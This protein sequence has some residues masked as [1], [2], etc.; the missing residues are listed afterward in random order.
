MKR[1]VRIIIPIFLS[2]AIIFSLGWY[3]LVYDQEFTRDVLVSS[4][5]Y[6]E[7]Q[8][9]HSF[10]GWLYDRAYAQAADNDEVAI[11]LAHQ[12]VKAGNYTLA[13]QT[14]S[15]A[16]RDGGGAELYIALS[17]IYVRQNKLRDAVEML[18]GIGDEKIRAQLEALRP[19]PPV[20]SPAPGLYSQYISI[21]LT[22]ESGQV[23][24]KNAT[25]YPSV[26]TDV[27]E[28]PIPLQ[29][30]EN[31]IYAVAV[32]E[33][34][35][36]SRLSNLGYTVGGVN[37][38]INFADQTM[39]SAI[40]QL[41]NVDE[42]VRI[43][44]SDLS[45]IRSFSVPAG[46]TSLKDLQYMTSLETLQIEQ[47]VSGEL[48]YLASL[49]NLTRLTIIDT[50]VKTE[51]LPVIGALPKLEILELRNCGLT[52]TSGL[53]KAVNLKTLD[54]SDNSIRNIQ[55]LSTMEQLHTLY[56]QHNAL[57]DLSSLSALVKL[58]NLNV[59]YNS[60]TTLAPISNLTGLHTLEAAYNK[61]A[62]VGSLAKM[63]A[64]KHL[65]L[66][67]NA[68]T[69]VAP[70][71][72]CTELNTLDVSDN[73]LTAISSLSALNKLTALDFSNNRVSALPQFAKDCALVTIDGTNNQISTLE[74]L[75]GLKN[76][77]N[78]F[79]DR[80][81]NISS[82]SALA[83]CPTLIQVNVSGTK[84][85]SLTTVSVLTDQSIIVNFDPS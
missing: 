13:E 45:E 44:S 52:T 76:L 56:L 59:S 61:L 21:T 6:F 18:D 62:D 16:I 85:H 68:I 15:R 54:L 72:A 65:I 42:S 73:S 24:A 41:L 27:Y 46:V 57:A 8:G 31:N 48:A 38:V 34:G 2:L 78:V 11:E 79:M 7:R 69:D 23:Y 70:L 64:L 10:A 17:D 84:I 50:A 32:A 83:K 63:T 40:R 80:N 26:D 82:V 67:H 60:L 51:E 12:H 37:E 77:N 3:L 20:A 9:N 81:A 49:N 14:L 25:Q 55:A 33:N 19:A 4:A 43:M 22:A 5:R 36:V 53:A 29:F 58:E 28:S 66:E 75:G 30:G 47:S 39:E 35:L 1:A 74:P 71:S